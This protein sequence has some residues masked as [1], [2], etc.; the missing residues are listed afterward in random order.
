MMRANCGADFDDTGQKN[1]VRRE[2]DL[3]YDGGD[4]DEDS[5]SGSWNWDWQAEDPVAGF[6]KD[7]DLHPGQGGQGGQ[8]DQKESAKGAHDEYRGAFS[9]TTAIIPIS[10]IH[11][12]CGNLSR[13]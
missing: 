1:R 7:G 10:P 8:G 5:G 11:A 9:Q 2:V 3:D 12:T 13:R 4:G 6:P